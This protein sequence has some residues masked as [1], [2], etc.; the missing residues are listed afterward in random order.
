MIE[1]SRPSTKFTLNTRSLPTSAV[2]GS[3]SVDLTFQFLPSLRTMFPRLY[4]RT[5]RTSNSIS[6][7]L[8][9]RCTGRQHASRHSSQNLS[10]CSVANQDKINM[11]TLSRS[12]DAVFEF[13]TALNRD[14]SRILNSRKARSSA[15]NS[16][17]IPMAKHDCLGTCCGHRG[18]DRLLSCSALDVVRLNR[19]LNE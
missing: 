3:S 11:R 17:P 13:M 18:R 7:E 16:E 10:I 4:V 12:F 2:S 14:W 9:G 1:A 8:S 6:S 5:P 15:V 19:S